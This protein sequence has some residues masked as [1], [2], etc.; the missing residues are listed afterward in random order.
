MVVYNCFESILIP[1]SINIL[2]IAV[3]G[4]MIPII[5]IHET[6]LRCNG[7]YILVLVLERRK[8]IR[9]MK[10][11]KIASSLNWAFLTKYRSSK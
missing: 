7:S 8:S 9:C 4:R 3:R 1:L 5:V 11:L 6:S 2:S 10:K